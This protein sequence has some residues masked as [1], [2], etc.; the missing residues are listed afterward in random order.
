[1]R[2]KHA[3][4]YGHIGWDLSAEVSVLTGTIIISIADAQAIQD[5]F[6]HRSRFPKPVEFYSTLQILGDNVVVTEGDTWKRHR[7]IC[8]PSFSE[9]NNKLVWEE[10][11]RVTS[12]ALEAWGDA[13][14]TGTSHAADF[15]MKIT[16]LVLA[17][18]SFGRRVS[19]TDS[20][21]TPPG[22]SMSFGEAVE[23]VAHNMAVKVAIP[24]PLLVLTPHWRRV[25]R[26]FAELT[27][28]IQE[29]IS[30][31]QV[32]DKVV[33]HDL[34]SGL[35]DASTDPADP[36]LSLSQEELLGNVFIFLMAGHE[37]TANTL[38]FAMALLA[39]CQDEQEAL[40]QDVQAVLQRAGSA[41]PRYEDI[42]SFKYTAAVV[43]ETLRLFPPAMG[44]PKV[45]AEA[46]T[47]TVGGVGKGEARTSISVPAGTYI[48][49][50]VN[51]LHRNPRYWR[52]PEAFRPARFLAADWPRDAF[53]AFAAGARGC[54]GRRFAEVESISFLSLFIS[55]FKID[56]TPEY[57]ARP[58]ETIEQQRDRLC[59]ATA[60]F[61]MTPL[62]LPLIFTR[63]S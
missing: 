39:L 53:I 5:M 47:I 23:V 63:R 33:R 15:T 25:R 26:A 13:T 31:R 4:R 48:T 40:F 34:L 38:A 44:I 41:V 56:L 9:Q 35:L 43:N 2:Q 58:G 60:A 59:D 62:H 11:I 42:N 1:M 3:G 57:T 51:G 28:Y 52:D 24:D 54:L 61:S 19:W 12:E 14:Q 10:S 16:L 45:A 50:D 20:S 30:Q 29:M 6:L 22:H 27:Q 37:T 7:K 49:M 36:L 8:A 18:A 46:C 21:G 17:A 32:G 55:R